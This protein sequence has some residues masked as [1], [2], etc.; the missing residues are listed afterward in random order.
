MLT[1]TTNTEA[2]PKNE[3]SNDIKLGPTNATSIK[4]R[5]RKNQKRQNDDSK[6]F[7]G[8]TTEMNG[9]LFQ[10]IEESKDATQYI[11][12][13]EVLKRYTFKQ[14][15]VDMSSLFQGDGPEMSE[16]KIPKKPTEKELI[17][18]PSKGDIYQLK[19][20]EYIKE[21]RN[22]KVALKLIWAII[23]GQC[24]TSFQTKLEKRK[25]MKDLKRDANVVKLLS[26]IQQA[27]MNY[28]DR[29]HPC[30]ILY[31]QF[32]AFHIYYQR[33]NL[34]I[35]NYLLIF[36]IIVENIERCGGEFGNDSAKLRYVLEREGQVNEEQY[37]KLSEE[38]KDTYLKMATDQYL[39]ISFLFGGTR[40]KYGQLVSNLK[41]AYI[42]G[43]DKYPKDLERMT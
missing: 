1:Q 41:N 7:V 30:V 8:E 26:Y 18:N 35:Q 43:E 32:S 33:K 34:P 19:L 29:H 2:I 9:Q 25:D 24:S 38:E 4:N 23:W 39:A 40:S 12:T 6:T 28:E 15:T 22:L 20:K 13:L 37:M 10:S 11:K 42:L 31:Q 5:F 21:E 27:C 3:A 17:K 16:V 14:Y 36:Q